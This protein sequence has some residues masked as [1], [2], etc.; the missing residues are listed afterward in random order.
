MSS[1]ANLGKLIVDHDHETG[2]IRELLCNR[3]NVVLGKVDD[4]AELLLRMVAY[5]KAHN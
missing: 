5:L 4:N 1:G 3:C 2:K